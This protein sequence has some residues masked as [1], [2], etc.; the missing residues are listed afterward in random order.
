M[1]AP[2]ASARIAQIEKENGQLR[3]CL[4][5]AQ[6]EL[7]VAHEEIAE[8]VQEIC[9]IASDLDTARVQYADLQE[10]LHIEEFVTKTVVAKLENA[11]L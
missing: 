10:R 6:W 3:H 5:V 7:K 11:E 9:D 1:S 2:S 8:L 4:A